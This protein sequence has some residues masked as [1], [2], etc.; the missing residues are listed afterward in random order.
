MKENCMKLN[1]MNMIN[2]EMLGNAVVMQAV[3]DYRREYKKLKRDPYNQ[4]A[5]DELRQIEKF[6]LSGRFNLFTDISGDKL[7]SSVKEMC[8]N[9]GKSN[10]KNK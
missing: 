2:I 10:R 4:H 1:S 9:E 6:F 3:K 8:E 5:K 7:L